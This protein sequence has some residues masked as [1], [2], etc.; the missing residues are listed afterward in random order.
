MP[1]EIKQQVAVLDGKVDVLVNLTARVLKTTHRVSTRQSRLEINQEIM[2]TNQESFLVEVATL[3]K[4][5]YK[6]NGQPPLMQRVAILETTVF[7]LASD[8]KLA[9]ESIDKIAHG[10]M[11]SRNQIIIGVLG[12]VSTALLSMGA[13]LAQLFK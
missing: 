11:L 4:A 9:L 12:I 7:N 5:I 1:E 10:K 2:K 13:I 3:N 6:G 8:V